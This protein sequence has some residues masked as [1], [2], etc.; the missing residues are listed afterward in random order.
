[1]NNLGKYKDDEPIQVE[2]FFSCRNLKN[3]DYIGLS[4]PH[5]TLSKHLYD[6]YW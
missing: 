5:L 2:L 6:V 1:M 3:T 4:D